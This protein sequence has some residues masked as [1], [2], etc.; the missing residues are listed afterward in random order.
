M[1]GTKPHELFEPQGTDSAYLGFLVNEHRHTYPGSSAILRL[2]YWTPA[3]TVRLVR[4]LKNLYPVGL[5]INGWVLWVEA[6]PNGSYTRHM[7]PRGQY[8][9]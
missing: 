2:T 9:S 7:I 6:N 4:L 3:A 8:E 1:I 5:A